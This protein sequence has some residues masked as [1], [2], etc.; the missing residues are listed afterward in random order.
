MEPVSFDQAE[1]YEP[2][3]GW[4]RVAMAGSD[5][6]SFEWFEKPPGH[7]SPMHDHENE[8][9]CLVTEGELTV[10]TEDDEV[11]LG[12][13]DSTWLEPWERHRVENT[14]DERA[15]GVDVFAPGRSFDFWL[16]RE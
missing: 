16:D 3:E 4:R 15:V 13:Y 14:G 11:T 12:P 10:Y 6:F 2:E 1:T 7:S 8:Q 5:A 9:V